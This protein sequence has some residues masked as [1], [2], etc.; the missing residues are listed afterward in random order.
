MFKICLF[1]MKK[2][3]K[4]GY[5][6]SIANVAIIIVLIIFSIILWD[7]YSRNKF[8]FNSRLHTTVFI[9][10]EELNV[11]SVEKESQGV[12][13]AENDSTFKIVRNGIKYFCKYDSDMTINENIYRAVYDI[14]NFKIWN[15]KSLSN[16]IERDLADLCPPY[17]LMRI[18]SAYMVL[19]TW[20]YREDCCFSE[21]LDQSYTIPL[22]FLDKHQL[23]ICYTYP[24]SFFWKTE[25]KKLLVIF[26]LLSLVAICIGLFL[27][28]VR[29]IRRKAANQEL[30]VQALNHDLKSPVAALRLKMYQMKLA[31]KEPYTKEQEKL[32]H[33]TLQQIATILSSADQVLQDSIDEKGITLQPEWTDIRKIIDKQVDIV[34]TAWKNKKQVDVHILCQLSDPVIFV[35]PNHIS[36]VILNIL[37]NA[38]KYSDEKVVIR[39]TCREEG[40]QVL[41]SLQDDGRGIDKRDLKHIFERNFRTGR[42]DVQKGYGIGLSY[43]KTVVRLHGGKVKVESEVG[44]GTTFIIKLRNGKKN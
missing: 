42:T 2:I 38:V 8:N 1:L 14:A 33:D 9:A 18:D 37:D 10:V 31:S 35:D 34:L 7:S 15:L 21:E 6:A 32:Y 27:V 20:A 16:I 29:N 13:S 22:G 4:G 43:V 3:T 44:K 26:I 5:C 23:R 41:I 39:I 36:R 40:E 11:K 17:Q 19:D 28:L 24:W 12:I 25:G 30:F